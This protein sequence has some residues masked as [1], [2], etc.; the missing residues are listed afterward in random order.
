M[1]VVVGAGTW[2][3]IEFD[4]AGDGN[5]DGTYLG[6]RLFTTQPNTGMFVRVEALHYAPEAFSLDNE[7][8]PF[9]GT[10]AAVTRA[11]GGHGTR[12]S[13]FRRST[14]APGGSLLLGSRPYVK[15]S[16]LNVNPLSINVV[17]VSP[18]KV[19]VSFAAGFAR[20]LQPIAG[21]P[22]DAGSNGSHGS[23]NSTPAGS[24]AQGMKRHHTMPPGVKFGGGGDSLFSP[25]SNSDS[26]DNTGSGGLSLPPNLMKSTSAAGADIKS[27]PH[28][29][30]PPKAPA[31][32]AGKP[33][34][35]LAAA[36]LP[37][38][39][40]VHT[41]RS[42]MAHLSIA[43]PVR[44]HGYNPDDPPT[45]TTRLPGAA[46]SKI[47][48]TVT[49]SAGGSGDSKLAG[50]KSPDKPRPILTHKDS[51]LNLAAK[52]KAHQ[53]K[54]KA[55]DALKPAVPVDPKIRAIIKIQAIARG[56]AV[57]N[58]MKDHRLFKAWSELDWREEQ[59]LV[60]IPYAIQLQLFPRFD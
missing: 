18:T 49:G 19:G 35:G 28:S 8:S 5:C 37:P 60:Y 24:V 39:N 17:A 57:R 36:A 33:P 44:Q 7:Q 15:P 1:V 50:G 22:T 45:P 3:G 4:T 16:Y 6:H 23:G 13:A 29:Q 21:S 47:A 59:D 41:Q 52:T 53:E 12:D 25:K 31:S 20:A 58:K 56:K 10:G 9:S 55:S 2:F 48:V 32:T 46:D 30:L 14:T 54:K 26:K 27:G 42:M 34:T 40:G 51:M 43:P 11:G 38:P